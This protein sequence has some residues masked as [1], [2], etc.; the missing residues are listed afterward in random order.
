MVRGN[1]K[2]RIKAGIEQ[3]AESGVLSSLARL[4]L[5]AKYKP[6]EAVNN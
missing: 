5:Q 1:E 6:E 2:E 4:G 3:Q